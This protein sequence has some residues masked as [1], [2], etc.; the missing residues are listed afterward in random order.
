MQYTALAGRCFNVHAPPAYR[1]HTIILHPAQPALL[2]VRDGDRWSLTAFELAAPSFRTVRPLVRHVRQ[3][4]GADIAVLRCLR[5]EY[6][7]T[8]H[9]VARVYVT[10]HL[11]GGWRPPPGTEWVALRDLDGR[12][13]G[14]PCQAE[15]VDRWLQDGDH[16][17]RVPWARPRWFD[18]ASQWTR[19]ELDRLGYR[20][21]GPVEQLRA[22]TVSTVM[23]VGTDRGPVCRTSAIMGHI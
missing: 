16:P 8:T 19:N 4:L 15:V 12:T 23:T 22:W 11:D 9:S 13:P 6:V 10:E 3:A 21:V 14:E 17:L 7:P 1:Y 18:A 5:N 20:L 2:A